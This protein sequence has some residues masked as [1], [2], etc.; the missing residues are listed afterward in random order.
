MSLSEPVPLHLLLQALEDGALDVRFE[1]QSHEA[2]AYNTGASGI[3][4]GFDDA[5]L[6]AV[7]ILGPAGAGN[8]DGDQDDQTERVMLSVGGLALAELPRTMAE[9]LVNSGLG[10][11]EVVQILRAW[12]DQ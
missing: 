4:Q 8:G 5:D 6:G 11:L 9:M 3:P 2:F 10:P 7:E 1:Q 12:N